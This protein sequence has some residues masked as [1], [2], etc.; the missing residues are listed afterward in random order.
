MFIAV[1]RAVDTSASIENNEMRL[2]AV[3]GIP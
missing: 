1:D 3:L 2:Q